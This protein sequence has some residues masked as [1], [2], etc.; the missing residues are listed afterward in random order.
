M[1]NIRLITVQGVIEPSIESEIV[2][3][4][5]LGHDN[6]VNYTDIVNFTSILDSTFDS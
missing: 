4:I 1:S 3:G 6:T 5:D 2:I